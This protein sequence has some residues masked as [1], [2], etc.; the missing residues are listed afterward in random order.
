MVARSFITILTVAAWMTTSSVGANVISWVKDQDRVNRECSGDP[1][2]NIGIVCFDT[3]I[4]IQAH[5]KG[6]SDG[7]EGYMSD[8]HTHFVL[9]AGTIGKSTY[10][11]TVTHRI[12]MQPYQDD[13]TGQVFVQY[14]ISSTK[15]DQEPYQA[16]YGPGLTTHARI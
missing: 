10:L 4:D 6:S 11:E 1:P 5:T 2:S 16:V 13:M 9:L 3:N 15:Q 12:D 14:T 7:L 8:D